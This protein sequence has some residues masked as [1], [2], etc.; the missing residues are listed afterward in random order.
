[1]GPLQVGGLGELVV[2]LHFK[3]NEPRIGRYRK[4]DPQDESKVQRMGHIEGG[5][6]PT[7]R[8]ESK[9]VLSLICP[10]ALSDVGSVRV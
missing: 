9:S 6:C 2:S 3:L 5:G 7:S 4:C 8:R 1:M 10:Q